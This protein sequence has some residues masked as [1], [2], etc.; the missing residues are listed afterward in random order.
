MMSDDP[1]NKS[2][3]DPRLGDFEDDVSS[4]KQRSLFLIAGSMLSEISIPQLVF[5]WVLSIALPAVLLGLAPLVATAWAATL[6]DE[7]A[8]FTGVG[9]VILLIISAAIGW[10]GWR[11]LLRMAETSFWSLNALAVQPGYAF[12]REAI[13][14]L[15]EQAVA[16]R[17]GEVARAK[18]RAISAAAASS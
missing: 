6:T 2:F 4:T 15:T 13:R 11:P 5:A 1:S 14:H 7:I 10:F 18:L 9:A 8:S 16:R 3:G 12:F 17:W